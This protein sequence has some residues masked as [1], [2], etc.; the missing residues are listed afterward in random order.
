MPAPDAKPKKPFGFYSRKGKEKKS[1]AK[2]KN[3]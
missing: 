1:A 2:K 3:E